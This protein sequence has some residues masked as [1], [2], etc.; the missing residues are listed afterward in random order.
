MALR[1]CWPTVDTS[2]VAQPVPPQDQG[3]SCECQC[4]MGY[5]GF[6][7]KVASQSGHICMTLHWVVYVY[8]CPLFKFQHRVKEKIQYV[9]M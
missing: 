7:T 2:E 8:Q 4:N 5:T 9:C 1:Q 3:A 6:S